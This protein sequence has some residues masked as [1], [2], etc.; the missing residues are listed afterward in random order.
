MMGLLSILLPVGCTP[1]PVQPARIL[2]G[3]VSGSNV[4]TGAPLPQIGPLESCEHAFRAEDC[5][6]R[7]L[8]DVGLSNPTGGEVLATVQCDSPSARPVV[9]VAGWPGG[10]DDL[11]VGRGS[12]MLTHTENDRCHLLQ[13]WRI[14]C[15]GALAPDAGEVVAT[16]TWTIDATYVP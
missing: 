9:T 3:S 8:C 13:S 11:R 15:Q 5:A 12:A 4:D 14:E 2:P 16:R 7:R 6:G 1:D 10:F